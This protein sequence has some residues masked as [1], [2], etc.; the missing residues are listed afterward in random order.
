[1]LDI[2]F[3]RDNVDLIKE[4]ARKK[5]IDVDID[6]LVA[7]DEKRRFAIA[8]ID[9]L[10]RIHREESDK[11]SQIQGTVRDAL[12]VQLKEGKDKI[13]HKE[14]ELRT[15]ENEFNEL[16]LQIPNIPDP[17][18][19]GGDSDADNQEIR[20]WNPV[21]EEAMLPTLASLGGRDY[22]TLMKEHNMLDIERGTKVAGFRGYFLKNDGAM[23]E[24]ALWRFALDYLST[25]GFVPFLAPSIVRRENFMGTGWV[26]GGSI[27]SADEDIYKTQDDLYL[28]GT[29]EVPMM[30]YHADEILN[31]S[32]LPKTYAA[33]SPCYRREIGTHGKDTKGIIRVHEFYKVEQIVLCKA[34]HQVSVDWH[35]ALTKNSEEIMQMLE[36]PYR[37][38]LNCGADL[39]LGQ[40]KKYDIEGW[41]P[42]ENKY[43]E[44]HSA[45]YFH[46]FQ[47][48]RLN[49]KYRDSEGKLRFVHSLNNTALA[50]PRLLVSFLENHQQLNGFIKIPKALQKY[51]GKEI[52]SK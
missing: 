42:S 6:R 20:D 48:R 45:S 50:V 7:L 11:T 28:S 17:S 26:G 35:E 38:V 33:F 30:G 14:F 47:T 23:L 15:I 37:V 44:T 12:I 32:D 36:I 13:S 21:G 29:A 49:I 51:F 3:I 43:R 19:P 8:D 1:M 46:D 4:A 52:I 9:D 10:R 39:G 16:M 18:V 31:E 2:K 34:D 24:L 40:V 5:K 22:L 25:K 27:N 41:V